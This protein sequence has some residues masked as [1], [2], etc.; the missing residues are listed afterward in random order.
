MVSSEVPKISTSK[1]T[2]ANNT[3]FKFQIEIKKIKKTNDTQK[4]D[5]RRINSRVF[6]EEI[7][8]PFVLNMD[9]SLKDKIEKTNLPDNLSTIKSNDYFNLVKLVSQEFGLLRNQTKT[10]KLPYVWKKLSSK[11]IDDANKQI[12]DDREKT[13]N[14]SQ[15]TNTQLRNKLQTVL[16][17]VNAQSRR[18]TIDVTPDYWQKFWLELC[19]FIFEETET[20][21]NADAVKYLKNIIVHLN[22]V[23]GVLVKF[24]S[25]D[26]KISRSKESEAQQHINPTDDGRNQMMDMKKKL[27]VYSKGIGDQ[28]SFRTIEDA[29][30]FLNESK[31]DAENELNELNELSELGIME[32]QFEEVD[33]MDNIYDDLELDE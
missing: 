8:L 22:D 9:E 30:I 1:I 16:R 27:G 28:T 24:D 25:L 5:T 13:L 18:R 20:E 19:K 6:N 21:S 33:G 14:K 2:K 4:I 23:N 7:E 15:V 12:I 29:S 32:P 10:F 11:R 17:Y 31:E 26:E 3:N